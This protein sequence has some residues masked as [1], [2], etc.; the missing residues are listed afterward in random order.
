MAQQNAV[1]PAAGSLEEQGAKLFAGSGACTGCHGI[2]GV[3]ITSYT[4]PKAAALV[5]P[6]LTHFG[7]RRL[8]AG[9]VLL[10]DPASC[11]IVNGQLVN[12]NNCGLYK[13]LQDPQAVKPGND[14]VI[15]Q[16]TD[17]QITQLI[18]YLESL[19]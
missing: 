17:A 2:V 13:W 12:K 4:D 5:G 3:N 18:A 11:Q 7:S 19:Q 14:M 9:G 10:W 15:G 8:I 16:L 1:K 6:N